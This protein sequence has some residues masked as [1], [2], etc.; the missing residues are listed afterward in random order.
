MFEVYSASLELISDISNPRV[1]NQ[2]LSIKICDRHM[3]DA[4][5][6]SLELISGM[7]NP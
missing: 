6:A 1:G 3:F 7:A 4:F 2:T 5:S